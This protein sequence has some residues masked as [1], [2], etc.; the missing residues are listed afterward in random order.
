MIT[1]I[2]LAEKPDMVRKTNKKRQT[3]LN[4]HLNTHSPKLNGERFLTS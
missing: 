3:E 4:L 2:S 1:K